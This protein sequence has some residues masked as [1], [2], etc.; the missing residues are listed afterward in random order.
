M[1]CARRAF[2]KAMLVVRVGFRVNE[3]GRFVEREVRQHGFF[4]D[5]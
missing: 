4:G 2:E 5:L 3:I 1:E